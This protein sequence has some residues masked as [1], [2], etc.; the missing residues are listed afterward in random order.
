MTTRDSSPAVLEALPVFPLP[1]IVL[2][3][4]A[5]MPLHI[6]EPRYR[7]MV[8][9]ALAGDSRLIVAQIPED[10]HLDR[11]GQPTIAPVA[12]LGEIIHSE[13]L[14]D[15]RY[16]ILL[17][18]KARVRL[19][20]LPFKRPYR[21][22]RATVLPVAAGAPG[23]P[24]MLRA[25]RHTAIQ[26]V[27]LIQA[28]HPDFEFHVPEGAPP[29]LVADLCAHHLVLCGDARQRLLEELEPARR[30]ASCLAAL[31]GQKTLLGACETL[32]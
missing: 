16:N 13:A 29:G 25:L 19:E 14:P 30:V 11:C 3:P 24:A 4:G 7:A 22:V 32:H 10:H 2:F 31:M 18:G 20:E 17:E 12:G 15:G 1:Q 28:S 5:T 26:V 27:E 6:F 21:R 8:R 9:D 23:D